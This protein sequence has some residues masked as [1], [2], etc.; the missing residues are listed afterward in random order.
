MSGNY[1]L[2]KNCCIEADPLHPL[3]FWRILYLLEAELPAHLDG[4]P[5][6]VKNDTS[7]SQYSFSSG[8]RL[9]GNLHID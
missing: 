4:P 9:I 2:I 3:S 6:L 8:T 1:T 7:L 5:I